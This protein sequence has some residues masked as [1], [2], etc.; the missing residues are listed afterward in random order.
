MNMNVLLPLFQILRND[1]AI[2]DTKEDGIASERAGVRVNVPLSKSTISTSSSIG[3]FSTSGI[4]DDRIPIKN[5]IG[6]DRKDIIDLGRIGMKTYCQLKGKAMLAIAL[7]HADK[8]DTVCAETM[9]RRSI[10][11]HSK[12]NRI[13]STSSAWNSGSQVT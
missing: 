3:S 5:G 6:A 8:V 9:I 13:L 11:K 4:D 12:M 10:T 7:T 2:E 1:L